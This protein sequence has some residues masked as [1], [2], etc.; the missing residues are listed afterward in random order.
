MTAINL[1][2]VLAEVSVQSHVMNKRWTNF[3]GTARTRCVLVPL[4]TSMVLTRSRL[5][6]LVGQRRGLNECF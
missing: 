5:S 1:P 3:F 6:G 2:D 4:K